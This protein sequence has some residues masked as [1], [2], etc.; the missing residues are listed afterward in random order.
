M[1]EESSP[2]QRLDS[3][4]P[5]HSSS[6]GEAESTHAACVAWEADRTC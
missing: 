1:R 5:D 3:G 6:D 4:G 2:S